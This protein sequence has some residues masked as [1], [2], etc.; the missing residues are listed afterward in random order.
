MKRFHPYI[1]LSCLVVMTLSSCD[2]FLDEK[3]DNRMDLKTKEDLKRLLVSAYPT[4]S[5]AYILEMRS[6]NTNEYHNTS[7]TSMGRMQDQAYEWQDITDV[8][9]NDNPRNLWDACYTSVAT[10]NEVIKFVD[11]KSADERGQYNEQIGEALLCRAYAMFVLAN[12]FCMAYDDATASKELG[13]PYP[14]EPETKVGVQYERGTLAE[15][16]QKIDNDLQRGLPIVGND[17]GTT[18]KFHFTQEA[19]YAFAARFYL[20]YRKYEEAKKYA[21]LVLGAAPVTKLRNWAY[22]HTLSAN[23]NVQPL[24]FISTASPANLLLNVYYSEWQYITGPWS[25]GNKYAHGERIARNETIKGTGPWGSSDEGDEQKDG[26][27][28]SVWSNSALSRV[29]IN[30]IPDLREVNQATNTYLPHTEIP[31]FTTDETLMVRAEANVMLGNY[32]E[33]L[34]DINT[35]LT[36]FHSKGKQITLENIKKYYNDATGVKYYTPQQPTARKKFN[37]SF[38]IEPTTQEPM[39]QCVLHLRRLL[40]LHEGL[41]MQD[42][43]RYGIE[44]YRIRLN[45][46]QAVEAITDH[47]SA[48][49]PRYAVQIPSDVVSA[50]MQPNPVVPL[51]ITT[52]PTEYKKQ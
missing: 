21:N 42:V 16:Y 32:D 50:G 29:F 24:E 37:T 2:D 8:S 44:V 20:Y 11:S 14:L 22:M 36:K 39:L 28:Y 30:K 1:I 13:L 27:N 47:F 45:E 49:D 10:A 17:Y 26:M 7:W 31:V 18:P 34:A 25:Y 4:N 23:G 52:A 43:K 48:G 5:P 40:T 35:E 6:D 15:L 46:S 41:R 12:T 51:S 38:T 33:A 19:G 9:S 3:P